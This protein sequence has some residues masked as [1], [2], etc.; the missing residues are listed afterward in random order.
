MGPGT[1][2]SA[3]ERVQPERQCPSMSG[4]IEG[5]ERLRM[6]IRISRRMKLDVMRV[7]R[8]E[9]VRGRKGLGEVDIRMD[10]KCV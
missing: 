8:L 3:V 6:R 7:E 2:L 5:R 1:V 9:G 4:R 10:S